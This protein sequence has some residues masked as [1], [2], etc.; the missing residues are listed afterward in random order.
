VLDVCVI[1][2]M[3]GLLSI[4]GTPP[5]FCPN[6]RLNIP[7]DRHLHKCLISTL[8]RRSTELPS[9]ELQF[10]KLGIIT[11]IIIILLCRS[12]GLETQALFVRTSFCTCISE[13]FRVIVF[14]VGRGRARAYPAG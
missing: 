11:I 1:K 12:Y 3:V 10:Y 9:S 5:S 8:E 14:T 13:F 6:T 2:T 4:S 7:E